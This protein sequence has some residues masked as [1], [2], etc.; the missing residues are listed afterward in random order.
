[1]ATTDR[2]HFGSCTK[3][4]DPAY[5]N[6]TLVDLLAHRASVREMTEPDRVLKTWFDHRDAA[7]S[8]AAL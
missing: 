8:P 6:V 7:P 5:A 2:W 4:M 1:M 3:S